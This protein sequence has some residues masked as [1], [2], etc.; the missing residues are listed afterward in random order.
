M[1]S[2]TM[3]RLTLFKQARARVAVRVPE[4]GCEAARARRDVILDAE[5]TYHQ[6][7]RKGGTRAQALCFAA[8]FHLEAWQALHAPDDVWDRHR[9]AATL[10]VE[11]DGVVP[12]RPPLPLLTRPRPRMRGAPIQQ[13]LR[14]TCNRV[15]AAA[16]TLAEPGC[17]S[18]KELARKV[19]EAS[20]STAFPVAEGTVPYVLQSYT[21]RAEYLYLRM[22][23][24]SHHV[25]HD[26]SLQV[27]RVAWPLLREALGRERSFSRCCGWVQ[28]QT[29][30]YPSG[31]LAERLTDVQI[32]E[33]R[34]FYPAAFRKRVKP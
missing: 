10:D 25:S 22:M 19:S 7:I 3:D 11:I 14:E 21:D 33:I 1:C 30:M 5:V 20:R 13:A 31:A 32:A 29:G 23:A 18:W 15:I 16:L 6:R 9:L 4:G 2:M 27:Q 34:R 28:A 8:L 17:K 24:L 26:G 12:E